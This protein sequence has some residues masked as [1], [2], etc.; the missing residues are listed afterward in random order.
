MPWSKRSG[1]CRTGPQY[2][3]S[4][5][6]GEVA[7]EEADQRAQEAAAEVEEEEEGVEEAAAPEPQIQKSDPETS[8]LPTLAREQADPD[9]SRRA[10]DRH[11]PA[12][13][14]R[15]TARKD[16]SRRST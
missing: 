4:A 14:S 10:S 8:A 12:A 6:V 13:A 9:Q 1:R 11:R 16:A 15:A 5:A 3:A 7:A 2:P